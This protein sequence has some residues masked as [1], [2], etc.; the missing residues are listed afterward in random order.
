MLLRKQACHASIDVCVSR[1]NSAEVLP[2]SG[3][4]VP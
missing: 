1:L 4:F 2:D 3:Q